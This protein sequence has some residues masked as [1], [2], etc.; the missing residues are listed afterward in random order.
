M[1]RIIE[2][3]RGEAVPLNAKWLKDITKVVREWEE[4]LDPHHPMS[5]PSTQ[6]EY[7]T[8]DVFKIEEG[9]CVPW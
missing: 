2:I 9:L 1:K 7:A 8:F 4:D 3:K 5:Y 6:Y